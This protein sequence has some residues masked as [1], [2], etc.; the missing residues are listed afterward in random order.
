MKKLFLAAIALMSVVC[1]NAQE[2]GDMSAG[3]NLNYHMFDEGS[4]FNNLGFGVKFRYNVT[5]PIRLEA[6]FNYMLEKD[7]A[8][9]Y[10]Y[11]VNA[12]YLFPLLDNKLVL[13]PVVGAGF[14][15]NKFNGD[16]EDDNNTEF[17][18]GVGAGADYAIT[19]KIGINIEAKYNSVG[20]D[21]D[22]SCILLSA[23]VTY[24]F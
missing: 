21:I 18:W 7:D 5:A 13:Y 22:D 14:M 11:T 1:A 4:D 24:K 16:G 20:G 8:T 15:T 23:G 10:D 6:N 2:A 12:H 3:V 17:M 9:V 19:D